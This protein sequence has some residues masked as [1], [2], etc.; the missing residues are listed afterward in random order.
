MAD[1]RKKIVIIGSG[2]MGC[3]IAQVFASRNIQT[4]ICDPIDESRNGAIDKIRTNL[5]MQESMPGENLQAARLSRNRK[6]ARGAI[7]P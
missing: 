5:Q 2:L 3:G 1:E 7:S 4:V 6:G